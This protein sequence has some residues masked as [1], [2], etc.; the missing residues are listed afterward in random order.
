MRRGGRVVKSVDELLDKPKNVQ[1]ISFGV[2]GAV[3]WEGAQLSVDELLL[4]SA[5]RLW[6]GAFLPGVAASSTIPNDRIGARRVT[7]SSII[8][9]VVKQ[10]EGTRTLRCCLQGCW[11]GSGR[12]A[13][14]FLLSTQSTPCTIRSWSVVRVQSL[15]AIVQRDVCERTSART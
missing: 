7:T 9:S 13:C 12:G 15:H 11:A 14:S 1:L 4:R 3:W 6:G 2:Q 5:R 8:V 10:R